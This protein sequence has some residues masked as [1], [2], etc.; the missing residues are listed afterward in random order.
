MGNGPGS[1]PPFGASQ[2]FKKREKRCAVRAN[3]AHFDVC[4]KKSTLVRGSY[5][6][7]NGVRNG[8]HQG[9]PWST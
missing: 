7:A 9:S 3:A 8:L 1:I 5:V 4:P 2:N 6:T